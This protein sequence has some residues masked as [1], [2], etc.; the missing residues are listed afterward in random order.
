M[1][2]R[3]GPRTSTERAG[4][5]GTS[6]QHQWSQSSPLYRINQYCT[7]LSSF[8]VHNYNYVQYNRSRLSPFS[9]FPFFSPPPPILS[10]LIDDRKDLRDA[11]V[12]AGGIFILHTDTVSS[13]RQLREQGIILP[14]PPHHHHHPSDDDDD[15]TTKPAAE[16]SKGKYTDTE[17]DVA[18]AAAT[19]MTSTTTTEADDETSKVARKETT[20]QEIAKPHQSAETSKEEEPS[21]TVTPS[22]A[23]ATTGEDDETGKV[24][25]GEETDSGNSQAH[26]P[27]MKAPKTE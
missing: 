22:A 9:F 20:R 4:L 23:V 8:I 12:A 27:K 15:D 14:K 7:V 2:L 16:Q 6:S 11:W 25:P 10:V 26:D 5:D 24:V 13:L 19:S 1:S 21:G 17:A 3:V 18:A